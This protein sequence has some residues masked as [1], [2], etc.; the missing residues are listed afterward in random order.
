MALPPEILDNILER[1]PA[2]GKGRLTL[3]ACALVATWGTGPSQRRLF[4]SVFIDEG[5]YE[6]WMNSVVLPRSKAHLLEYVRSLWQCRGLDMRIKYQMQDLAQD[7]GG[8]LLALRNLYGLTLYAIRVEHINA[9]Q[10]RTCFSA[11]RETLT[12]LSLENFATSFSAFVTLVDYFPNIATLQIDW[13]EV[14]SDER[15]VPSLSRPLRGKLDLRGVHED[16]LEFFDRFSKLDLGYEELAISN[17]YM[18][19]EEIWECILRISTSSV[20][21]LRLTDE[22]EREQTPH[23]HH[24]LT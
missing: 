20:K 8:Y 9:D 22:H 19:A 24:I 4:S 2:N 16:C 11:F 7:S 5:N 18:I 15:P 12:Y 6:R 23:Q 3:A 10:F 14:E 17:S 13:F 1:I 21:F